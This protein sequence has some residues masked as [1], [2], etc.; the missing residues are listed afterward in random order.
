M[1][2]PLVFTVEQLDHGQKLLKR[3][4]FVSYVP[5]EFEQGLT[6]NQVTMQ[7]TKL[8]KISQFALST[9]AH[10]LQELEFHIV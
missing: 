9:T 8:V 1:Y 5:L 4:K 2:S 10:Q 7:S 3:W 6:Y